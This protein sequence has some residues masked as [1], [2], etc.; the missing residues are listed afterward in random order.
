MLGGL[1]PAHAAVLVIGGAA[2]WCDLRT[3]HIPNIVTFGGAAAGLVYAAA[4]HGPA[5]LLVSGGGWLTGVAVF[6]PFFLLGGMGAGD[7]KLV[8]CFGAWLG[9]MAVLMV[10][11]YA[12]LAGGVMA[13]LLALATGYLGEAWL[14]VTGLLAHFRTAGLKPMPELTSERAKGPRLPYALPITIGAVAA[15]WFR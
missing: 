5:G 1:E 11:L 10:A 2:C 8:A 14:N 13:V 12:A 6:L 7:I 9:P 4:A 15:I 3:R